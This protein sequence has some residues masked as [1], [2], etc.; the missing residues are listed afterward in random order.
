MAGIGF[1]MKNLFK[2]SRFYSGTKAI[3][4]SAIVITG[5][6]VLCVLLITFAQYF[7][8]KMHTP[9]NEKELFLAGVLYS[10]IFSQM[11]TSGMTMVLFRYV[12]DQLFLKKIES[13]L[14]SLYG[15]IVI[16]LFFGGVAG[17]FLYIFSDIDG[18]FKIFSYCFFMELI[19]IWLLT[20][21]ISALKN[22]FGIVKG[23]LSGVFISVIALWMCQWVH[24]GV[25]EA[26]ICMDIGFFVVII[27]FLKSIKRR[28]PHNNRDYFQFLTYFEK[29]PML[30]FIGFFYTFSLYLHNF[31]VWGSKIGHVVNNT[32]YISPFYD[33]PVFY[34]YLTIVPAMIMY[35]LFLE[36]SFYDAYRNFY[37]GIVGSYSLKEIRES[38]T[39]M[40]EVLAQELTKVM[41]IQLFFT[42]FA[43]FI[44]TKMLPLT[45]E[46]VAV[47]NIVTLGNYFLMMMFIIVQ[48]LLYFDDQK[49][50]LFVVASFLLANIIIT[51]VTTA[52]GSYGVSCFFAGFIS[53]L[54]AFT[55][56]NYFRKNIAYYIFCAQPLFQ[57]E[58]KL[59]THRLIKKLNSLNG[60]G[61]I[62]GAKD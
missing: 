11:I 61:G 38:Q 19:I 29:H 28:F 5:P 20:I 36:T 22:Y 58:K 1:H 41:E 47:F 50:A 59:Y 9:F 56:L 42:V 4:Y 2:D 49:G 30:F 24:L 25:T 33:T 31:I 21:Y 60:V 62:Y 17:L 15:A 44:G 14:A 34:A 54:L 40:F 8:D 55:R 13:I 7:L 12:A 39:K 26:F 10:F 45:I 57:K 52:F 27:L 32:F 3:T 46:Q 51:P 18:V 23:F 53:M 37:S 35:V 43:I 6:M 16:G 48:V